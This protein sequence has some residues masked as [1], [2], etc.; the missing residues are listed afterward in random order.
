MAKLPHWQKTALAATV[1]ALLGLYGSSAAALSLGRVLVLSSLGEPLRAEI[2]IP[3]VTPAE[4]ATLATSIASPEAFRQAGLD[5]H[6]AMA[7]LRVTLQRRPDGRPFIRLN[8]DRAINEPFVDLILE[9]SWATG[10]IVRDYT[11]LFDP[12][13]LRQAMPAPPMPAQIP[14]PS[15]MSRPP[16]AALPA[17]LPVP[18][19]ATPAPATAM[20]RASPPPSQ[21]EVAQPVQITV[22]YG[23]TAYRIAM[24]TRP[25]NISLDQM[26]VALLRANPQAFMG[27]NVNRFKAGAV[28]DVPTAE[29]ASATPAQEASQM[30]R[31]QSQDFNAYRRKLA[32]NAPRTA[33]ATAGRE[34]SGRVQ[35]TVQEDKPLITTPDKLTLSKGALQGNPAE[36]QLAK[37]RNAQEAETRAAEIAKNIS[38]LT[39]LSA[40]S[41]SVAAGAV[42]PSP[43]A[44][45]PLPASSAPAVTAVAPVVSAMPVESSLLASLKANA[46]AV[47]GAIG[48]LALLAA[49]GLYR[50]RQRPAP[51][52]ELE[53]SPPLENPQ[54]PEP[55]FSGIPAA[56]AEVEYLAVVGTK[57]PVSPEQAVPSQPN[58]VTSTDDL[59][60]VAEAEVYLAYGREAQAEEILRDALLTHPERLALHQKL[61]EI[62]AKRQ[63]VKSFEQIA[64]L[65]H[66]VSNG[67]GPEWDTMATMGLTID[68]SNALYQPAREEL[69]A[70]AQ[71]P[72]SIEPASPVDSVD[73]EVD[74]DLDFNFTLDEKPVSPLVVD[75]EAET[76]KNTVLPEPAPEPEYG[77]DLDFNL[78]SAPVTPPRVGVPDE[79]PELDFI[80]PEPSKDTG[81]PR[82]ATLPQP[83]SPDLDKLEFDLDDRSLDLSDNPESE[84]ELTAGA[85]DPLATKLALAEEFRAIGDDDGAR[86]LIEE[87]LAEATGDMKVKAQR[88]LNDL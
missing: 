21:G 70:T 50:R 61:L 52:A 25:D 44:S 81:E 29:Q 23:D 88:A 34:A 72:A 20:P 27:D 22:R 54:P 86:A 39:Q 19:A 12:P 60:P 5:Y 30:I 56:E 76:K 24:A 14:A 42:T 46:L 16:I 82:P 26:L 71:P 40:A 13:S 63:D 3:E 55:L 68:A 9:A 32:S 41:S 87:V 57:A 47:A 8:G 64:T 43:S 38:D 45:E 65:A 58:P 73:E 77:L 66:Q 83:E 62:L 51:T 4:A 78:D 49:W 1:A 48:L 15:A 11:L 33:V 75:M 59:D 53:P 36:E 74:R 84:A 37:E 6:P 85:E 69:A 79:L 67:S 28:I 10:R 31:A 18:A 35:A 2:D 80:L 17:P 7:G